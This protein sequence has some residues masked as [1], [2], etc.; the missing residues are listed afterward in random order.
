MKIMMSESN[1]TWYETLLTRTQL[2]NEK[3]NQAVKDILDNV[4]KDKDAAVKRYTYAFD[5]ALLPSLRVT[6]EEIN[7]AYLNVDA[8]LIRNLKYAKSNI[9]DYHQKQSSQD[10]VIERKG[11]RLGQ[12]TRAIETVGIYVPG[13]TAAYPS[14][15]LMNAIPAKM[16][17]VKRIIMVTPP[18][19]DGKINPNI[20]VAAHLV[21]IDAIYKV[22]GAQAIGALAYGTEEIPKVNKIVGPGNIYVAVAKKMVM[23]DVGI[24]MIA[25][26]SEVLIIAD[27][28]ANSREVA[29]DLMAQAEHDVLAASILITT[30]SD[31][32]QRVQDDINTLSMKLRRRDIIQK[33]MDQYGAIVIVKSLDEAIAIA[34]QIAP[35]HLEI[36]TKNPEEVF[37]KIEHAGSVFL[38]RFTP[39][40]VGDYVAGPNHTLPTS[41]TATFASPLSVYDFVKRTSYISYTKE[42]LYEASSYVIG[43]ADAEGLDAHA[44][45]IKV[46]FDEDK[47]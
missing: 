29:S 33:A 5:G 47:R 35:E 27:E 14:T 30:S 38:G 17:G 12:R 31:L 13:G 40:P 2:T 32:A 43:L 4:K 46:R 6:E 7:E 8:Q 34:N 45:A 16:A 11:V 1:Q 23:G 18:S 36:M 37:D 41:G 44:C 10:F 24:D 39:E 3:V 26:P 42:A 9:E 19:R 15:V 21:G 20:L 28:T 22:G 25:G